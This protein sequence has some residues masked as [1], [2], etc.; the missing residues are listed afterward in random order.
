MDALW[1]KNAVIYSL[2]VATFQDTNGDGIGDLR[3]VTDRLDYLRGLGVTCLWLLPCC[4]RPHGVVMPVGHSTGRPTAHGAPTPNP[5]VATFLH[6][7]AK[8]VAVFVS[9]RRGLS[10]ACPETH[11]E[12]CS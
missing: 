1:F 3:G 5:G 9:S 4:G 8:T 11:R 12:E 6:H 2:D 10:S 7:I